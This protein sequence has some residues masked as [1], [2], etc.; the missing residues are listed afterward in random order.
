M[1][2]N[3]TGKE[4]RSDSAEQAKI[5]AEAVAKAVVEKMNECDCPHGMSS[6]DAK[7]IRDFMIWYK[8]ARSSVIK[9]AAGFFF[10]GIVLAVMV[11]G[12]ISMLVS[13]KIGQ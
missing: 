11:G 8:D 12:A 10:K 5:I 7:D 6:N 1:D 9:A 3:Y 2:K 4:R 13:K